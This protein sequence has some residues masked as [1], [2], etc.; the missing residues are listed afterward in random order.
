MMEFYGGKDNNVRL[1]LLNKK[2]T[3]NQKPRNL[4]FNQKEIRESRNIQDQEIKQILRGFRD[5]TK[6]LILRT[7]IRK[8]NAFNV[9]N[10]LFFSVLLQ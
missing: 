4:V 1:K 7:N 6:V 5:Q 3:A 9:Q 8:E 2:I 10:I